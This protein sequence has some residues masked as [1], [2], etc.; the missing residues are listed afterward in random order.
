MAQNA[1]APIMAAA[2]VDWY[3]KVYA[4][5]PSSPLFNVLGCAVLEKL[6]PT[7]VQVC[8]L[9]PLRD[10]ALVYVQELKKNGVETNLKVY[11]GV[12]HGFWGV[13]PKW[14]KSRRFVRDTVD[15]MKWLLQNKDGRLEASKV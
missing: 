15:G 10:D 14:E 3:E 11:D 6:P 2:Q 7:F 12:S 9:D 5:D 8:G 13:F 4:G 1:Q